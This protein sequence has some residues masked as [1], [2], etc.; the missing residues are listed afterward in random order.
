MGLAEKIEKFY[1]IR[2]SMI[3]ICSISNDKVLYDNDKLGATE[4]YLSV[5][6]EQVKL[7]HFN[8]YKCY[9]CK[10]ITNEV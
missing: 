3:M 10:R 8:V 6:I 2:L 9:D 5:K 1:M 7:M 4:A